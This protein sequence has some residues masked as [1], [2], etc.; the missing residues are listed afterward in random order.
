MNP[1]W[2]FTIHTDADIEEFLKQK[3]PPYDYELLKPRHI[4]EKIDVWRLLII[5]YQ[6]GFYQDIDRLFNVPLDSLIINNDIKMLLPSHY[7]I[8]FAKDIM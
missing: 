3:L 4:V 1:E 7:D 6:G 2:D 8:T 5:Y